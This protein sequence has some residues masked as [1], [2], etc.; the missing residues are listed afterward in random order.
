MYSYNL[1]IFLFIVSE[2]EI[3]QMWSYICWLSLAC[4]CL[5]KWFPLKILYGFSS[6]VFTL[7]RIIRSDVLSPLHAFF[8]IVLGHELQR[9][10][11]VNQWDVSCVS[12]EEKRGQRGKPKCLSCRLKTDLFLFTQLFSVCCSGKLFVRIWILGFRCIDQCLSH[13]FTSFS[14]WYSSMCS[15][16][17]NANICSMKEKSWYMSTRT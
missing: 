12:V 11:E 9:R 6:L 8:K 16:N 7:R 2:F 4:T 1:I 5:Y 3:S 14:S 10:F 13:H 15:K 17:L